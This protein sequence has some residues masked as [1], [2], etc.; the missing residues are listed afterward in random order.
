L[1][2]AQIGSDS[3]ALF[4]ERGGDLKLFWEKIQEHTECFEAANT[5]VEIGAGDCWGTCALKAIFPHKT[6]IATEVSSE[7]MA[8]AQHW[9]HALRVKLDGVVACPSFALPFKDRSVDLLFAFQSAHH[10]LR[11]RQTFAELKRVLRT[12][13]RVLYLHE[14]S[15][16]R[17]FYPL[18]RRWLEHTGYGDTE[19]VLIVPKIYLL[20][21]E[22]GF[23]TK[24]YLVP[25]TTNKQP[26]AMVYFF[27][28]KKLPL[29]RHV[30]PCIIDLVLT[31]AN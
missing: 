22:E 16:R 20:A 19:D 5:I 14:P 29:L 30:F 28:L 31:K 21:R 17:F 11:H 4:F 25:T 1:E 18:A 9:E 8:L 26:A 23:V 24:Q 7:R 13:G 10:F 6:V 27:L 12:G 2:P 3:V 15:S